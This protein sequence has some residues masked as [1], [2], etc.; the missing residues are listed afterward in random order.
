M[1]QTRPRGSKKNAT[2]QKVPGSANIQNTAGFFRQLSTTATQPFRR[3]ERPVRAAREHV[4]YA[5][6]KARHATAAPLNSSS[7]SDAGP[8]FVAQTRS[9][10]A[11]VNRR[12]AFR[13]D[14]ARR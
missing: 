3:T 8:G 1:I 12:L 4:D 13:D 7:R 10:L 9:F 2:I 11:Y 6:D 5:R 14:L